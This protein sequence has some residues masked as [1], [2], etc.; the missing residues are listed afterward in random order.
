MTIFM[1]FFNNIFFFISKIK[2]FWD[3]D[4]RRLTMG[5][6]FLK[7][8]YFYNLSYLNSNSLILVK[9]KKV[10]NQESFVEN[11]YYCRIKFKLPLSK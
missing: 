4:K 7:T 6:K 1:F 2:T 8:F 10:I 3:F 5:F 9:L 11:V